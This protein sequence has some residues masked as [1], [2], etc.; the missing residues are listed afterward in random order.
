MAIALTPWFPDRAP[1]IGAGAIHSCPSASRRPFLSIDPPKHDRR[2]C[3]QIQQQAGGGP[4]AG[5]MGFVNLVGDQAAM[6]AKALC[7][8]V[9]EETIAAGGD[10]DP[11]RLET[12]RAVEIEHKDQR[13]AFEGQNMVRLMKP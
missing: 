12:P 5:R 1:S 11:I 7:V 2:P 10:G 3:R 6:A 8:A 4:V 9:Q 13:A